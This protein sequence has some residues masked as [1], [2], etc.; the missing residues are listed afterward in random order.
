[1]WNVSDSIGANMVRYRNCI[2]ATLVNSL[3]VE[4]H[5]GKLIR[6]TI[7]LREETMTEVRHE[8]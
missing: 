3:D 8:P 4:Q 6:L 1:L 7:A 2:R 5:L